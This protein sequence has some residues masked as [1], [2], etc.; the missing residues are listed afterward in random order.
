[1][2]GIYVKKVVAIS[3]EKDCN[4]VKMW[5]KSIK[6]HLYWSA[7][8]SFNGEETVAKW[9]YLLY[10]IQN[11]HVHENPFFPRCLH[12]PPTDKN[13]WLKPATK[14]IFKLVKALMNKHV[15]GD[16]KKLSPLYQTS[17]RDSAVCTQKRCLLILRNALQTL[18]GCIA[19]YCNE[20]SARK[21]CPYPSEDCSRR[22]AVQN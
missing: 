5:Q 20:N 17:G 2:Y 21:F 9:T 12:P 13:K 8:S 22:T 7:S 19:F 14:A 6:N 3:K 1:M 15:L 16:V 4:M 10:R 11:V 18:P